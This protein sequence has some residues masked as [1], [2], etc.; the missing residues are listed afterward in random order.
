MI[1]ETYFHQKNYKEA[2]RAYSKV[3]ILHED[4]PRWRAAALL[5]MG[6]VYEQLSQWTAAAETYERLRAKYPDDPSA[7]E[8]G[9]RRAKALKRIAA[10]GADDPAVE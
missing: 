9:K 4:A 3:E 2:L 6:K 8:A 10:A 7:Q 5:E 1:G